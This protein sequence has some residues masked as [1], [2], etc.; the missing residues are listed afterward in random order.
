MKVTVIPIIISHQRIDA[1]TGGLEN[2]RKSGDH[3]KY[4]NINISQ[5]TEESLGDL[6]SLK[7]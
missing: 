7:L 3:P 1:G 6:F 5:N 2:K 4:S